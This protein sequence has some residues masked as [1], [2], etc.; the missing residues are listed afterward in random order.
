MSILALA[1]ATLLVLVGARILYVSL[2]IRKDQ[3][4]WDRDPL[5]AAH[6]RAMGYTRVPIMTWP[7]IAVG[8]VLVL[9]GVTVWIEVLA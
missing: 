6:A 3:Q 4:G 5:G 8:V 7:G 1:I 9:I 2:A